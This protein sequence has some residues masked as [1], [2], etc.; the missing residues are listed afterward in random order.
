MQPGVMLSSAI[1]IP[2]Q[3]EVR[4]KEAQGESGWHREGER[5]GE[6]MQASLHHKGP[7]KSL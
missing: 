5:L 4:Q 3:Y 1:P 6:L 2:Q 7:C